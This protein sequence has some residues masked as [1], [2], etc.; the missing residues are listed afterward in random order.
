MAQELNARRSNINDLYKQY[1]GRSARPD[2]VDFAVRTGSD[3]AGRLAPWLRQQKMSSLRS[4][5]DTGSQALEKRSL[6][7]FDLE[8]KLLDRIRKD[9]ELSQA[10]QDYYTAPDRLRERSD[11]QDLTPQQRR[12]LEAQQQAGALERVS[13]LGG[14][15]KDIL[16]SL[17]SGYDKTL[18]AEKLSL[19][20]KQGILEQLQAEA[21][22]EADQQQQDFENNLA[23]QKLVLSK[24]SRASG[25]RGGGSRSASRKQE[26]FNAMAEG[27]S[28]MEQGLLSPQEYKM[29]I[30]D[31]F[32]EYYIDAEKQFKYMGRPEKGSNGSGGYWYAP[33]PDGGLNF[34]YG[35][36]P[37]DS[38]TY[39][40]AV[41]DNSVQ[42]EINRRNRNKQ[43]GNAFTPASIFGGTNFPQ[44]VK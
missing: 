25:G 21:Q 5:I 4:D 23:L 19:E 9:K 34:W 43:G 13:S 20:G 44:G 31:N 15:L 22:A 40:G 30:R 7:T 28:M 14:G 42:A 12:S 35:D 39:I 29:G 6:G 24:S 32:P 17:K 2:E 36:N 33:S 18:A 37:I 16:E 38:S 8:N 11:L 26:A 3:T 27:L 1:F 10:R 41:G